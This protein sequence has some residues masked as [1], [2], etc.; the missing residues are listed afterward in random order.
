MES[1]AGMACAVRYEYGR[2]HLHCQP[3]FLVNSNEEPRFR[4]RSTSTLLGRYVHL[5]PNTWPVIP[6]Q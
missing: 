1:L 3:I 4:G 2:S 6:I 5:L